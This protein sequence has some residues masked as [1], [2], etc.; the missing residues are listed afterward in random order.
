MIHHLLMHLRYN[1]HAAG[2]SVQ[3]VIPQSP[4]VP[5][6]DPFSPERSPNV[7]DVSLSYEPDVHEIEVHAAKSTHAVPNEPNSTV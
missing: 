1:Y 4:N 5:V 7:Q 2:A 6:P 3:P